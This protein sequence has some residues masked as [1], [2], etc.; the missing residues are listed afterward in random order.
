MKARDSVRIKRQKCKRVR[1]PLLLFKVGVCH[2]SPEDIDKYMH[3]VINKLDE[4]K[5]DFHIIATPDHTNDKINII[6]YE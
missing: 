5:Q 1:K 4:V 3:I 6:R 2:I